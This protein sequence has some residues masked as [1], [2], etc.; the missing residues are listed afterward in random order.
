MGLSWKI[1]EL[2]FPQS[3]VCAC[4]CAQVD[5]ESPLLREVA[6]WAVRNLCEGNLGIQRQIEELQ[7]VDVVETP[8][9]EAAG[10]ALQHDPTTGKVSISNTAANGQ[11]SGGVQ[12]QQE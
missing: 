6:L 2:A 11:H 3:K 7:V 10:V 1:V 5:D 9:M 4:A 8:E 12:K